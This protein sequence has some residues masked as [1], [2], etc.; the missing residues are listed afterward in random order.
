M[1]VSSAGLT[2]GL[3]TPELKNTPSHFTAMKT[4]GNQYILSG[5]RRAAVVNADPVVAPNVVTLILMESIRMC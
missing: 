3:Q 5:A 2:K 4:S 1:P